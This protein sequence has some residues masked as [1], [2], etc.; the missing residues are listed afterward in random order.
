L[1]SLRASKNRCFVGAVFTGDG[2]D[3]ARRRLALP[4]ILKGAVISDWWL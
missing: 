3:L 1:V 4:T 2:E